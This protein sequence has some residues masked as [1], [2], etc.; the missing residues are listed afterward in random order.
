MINPKRIII[1]GSSANPP[2]LDHL[3]LLE[4]IFHSRLDF[5]LMIWIPCGE[6]PN[7]HFS[8]C[9]QCQA[10][11]DEY[12]QMCSNHRIA[13]TEMTVGKFRQ[14]PSLPYFSIWYDDV[15]GTNTPTIVWLQRLVQTYPNS[16]ITW[17]TGS[18]SVVPQERFGG[19]NEIQQ[20]WKDG[21]NL[22]QCQRWNWLVYQRPGYSFNSHALPSNVQV[23]EFANN[24]RISSSDIRNL[25]ASGRCIWDRMVIPE[26]AKYIKQWKLYG[27]RERPKYQEVS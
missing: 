22:W 14:H 7:K 25:I 1:G 13:M 8:V 15:F 6:R 2:H 5:D 23:A 17:V 12:C 10:G 16:E 9:P 18:D 11:S 21:E 4:D 26:V 3:S 20:E 27:Y 19:K 24:Q